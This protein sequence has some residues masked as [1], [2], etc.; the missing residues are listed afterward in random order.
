MKAAYCV[1]LPIIKP[2]MM[3]LLIISLILL[4]L[5]IMTSWGGASSVSA[6]GDIPS[7]TT[8]AVVRMQEVSFSGSTQRAQTAA[9]ARNPVEIGINL[10]SSRLPQPEHLGPRSSPLS[11]LEQSSSLLVALLGNIGE[12]SKQISMGRVPSPQGFAQLQSGSTPQEAHPNP[13]VERANSIIQKAIL[14][15]G[16]EGK[17]LSVTSATYEYQVESLGDTP[18]KPITIKTSFKNDS[19][20]RSEA[21]G[22]NLDAITIL[23]GDKGWLKVGDTTLS[24]GRKEV[25]P[26]KTSMITQLRPELLLLVFPKRRYS[27]RIEESD[28][29][30]DQVE[31]SGFIGVEYV[32]GRFSFDVATSRLYKY[33]YEIERESAKGKGIVRGEERYLRYGDRD[34]LK[35]PEEILSKQVKKTSRLKVLKANFNPPLSEDLFQDPTPPATPK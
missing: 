11:R 3:K 4:L 26:L 12:S 35:F 6:P 19:R 31:I 20:F 34:G 32:R 21:F 24:L 18:S 8:T 29:S 7:V 25:D 30:L 16:G 1:P 10:S 33:E 23:N 22:D 28:L 2:F 27:G 17:I 9:P 5:M 13:S 15:H 14:A